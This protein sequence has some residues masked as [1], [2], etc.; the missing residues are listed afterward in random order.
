MDDGGYGEL[1]LDLLG[2][3][4]LRRDSVVV[5]V[6][7]RQQRLIAALALKGPSLRS[8]LVGLLW[9]EYPEPRA[10]ESLRVSVHLV[11]R[12]APGLILNAGSVLSLSEQVDID[13][14]RVRALIRAMGQPSPDHDEASGLDGLR[15][16]ELLPGWYDDWVIFEHARLQHDRL[17][18]FMGIAARS[19]GR[20]DF[21]TAAAAANA[22]VE[23][24]PLYENAV[25]LLVTA[26]MQAGNPAAALRAY[27][28]YRVQLEAELGL[29]P[30][31]SV[32]RPVVEVLAHQPPLGEVTLIPAIHSRLAGQ[33]ALDHS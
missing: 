3:W 31:E 1:K 21:G 11:S 10:L 5:H 12:Q 22:A 6:A 7:A 23:V 13:L 27:E 19:L 14:N 18:A 4:R 9:P 26:E 16:G 32:R 29:T 20:G 33:P 17:R 8:Y 24:E 25:R 30:S 28:R 2:S 15:G